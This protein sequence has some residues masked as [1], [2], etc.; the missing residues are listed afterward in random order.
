[1]AG[2]AP[3]S[4]ASFSVFFSRAALAASVL[5]DVV[6]Q[7][8]FNSLELYVNAP[9]PQQA[10]CGAPQAHNPRTFKL[11]LRRNSK[12]H[13]WQRCLGFVRLTPDVCVSWLLVDSGH[14]EYHR[15]ET[16]HLFCDHKYFSRLVNGMKLEVSDMLADVRARLGDG[17]RM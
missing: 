6:A 2:S 15:K 3:L 8:I 9:T 17:S 16:S 12:Q 13:T 5:F 1:M 11:R 10:M 14:T 4:S 7:C